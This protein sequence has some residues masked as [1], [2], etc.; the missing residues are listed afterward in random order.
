M[1][2]VERHRTMGVRTNAETAED[3]QIALNFGAE[4]I[5]LFRIEHMFYGKNS[6]GSV[7]KI[8]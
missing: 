6:E 1:S 2:V 7:V 8:T 3:A 5:G 4:G